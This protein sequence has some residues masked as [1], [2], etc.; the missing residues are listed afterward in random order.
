VL[1]AHSFRRALEL[2]TRPLRAASL[3]RGVAW[4]STRA[5]VV[6]IERSATAYEETSSPA[7]WGLALPRPSRAR[8]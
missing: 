5:L 7:Y 1:L 8:V 6:L 4:R 2:G 3:G